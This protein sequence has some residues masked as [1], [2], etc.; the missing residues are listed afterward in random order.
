MAM[1]TPSTLVIKV[2]YGD[3]QRRFIAGILGE[4]LYYSMDGLKKKI[5]FLFDISPNVELIL[6]YTDRDGDVMHLV[7][8]DDICDVMKQGLNPLRLTL[9]LGSRIASSVPSCLPLQ[10][11]FEILKCMPGPLRR[12]LTNNVASDVSSNALP[13]DVSENSLSVSSKTL[14]SDVS[15]DVS[16]NSSSVSS[17]T[18]PSDVS[19]NSLSN[20]S[21]DHNDGNL[22]NDNV[23][24]VSIKNW[25]WDKCR[26]PRSV[27][28]L[29]VSPV[30][31]RKTIRACCLANE[32]SRVERETSSFC[33]NNGFASQVKSNDH[34]LDSFIVDSNANIVDITV[35]PP[36]TMFAKKWRLRNNGTVEWPQGTYLCC[37]SGEQLRRNPCLELEIPISGV[38]VGDDLEI[39]VDFV[40]P[41][42]PGKYISIW[43]MTSPDRQYFGQALWVILQVD[44]VATTLNYEEDDSCDLSLKLSLG[45][46]SSCINSKP[47][48]VEDIKPQTAEID[49]NPEPIVEPQI[50]DEESTPVEHSSPAPIVDD[51]QPEIEDEEKIPIINFNAVPIVEDT[52]PQT[53]SEYYESEEES[54]EEDESEEESYEETE[55]EEESYEE[56]ESEEEEEESAE[57]TDTMNVD[58][59]TNS[60][61]WRPTIYENYTSSILLGNGANDLW[62]SDLCGLS[63]PDSAMPMHVSKSS[64]RSLRSLL[65]GPPESETEVSVNKEDP[66]EEEKIGIVK[67]FHD[68]Y[69]NEKKSEC[70]LDET[71]DDDFSDSD[72]WDPM[73][74]ELLEMGFKDS[75]TNKKLLEKNNGSIMKVVL[76]LIAEEN[77]GF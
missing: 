65:Y 7:D 69:V 33:D 2:K 67:K 1:A 45:S 29:M 12:S 49:S 61:A 20:T 34:R 38:P 37:T 52:E 57:D 14:P 71:R 54:Y 26:K 58:G 27:R 15:E 70:E 41:E 36:L 73:L 64:K 76:D 39:F 66:A 77:I 44:H 17:K 10:G 9:L 74:E 25:D 24:N 68:M 42:M 72:D 6:R 5:R 13:S 75:E 63:V 21:K 55:S 59:W 43:T 62:I 22:Q 23:G 50:E 60:T 51:T 35:T 28:P 47:A 18:L 53:E 31:S 19:E 8:D 48:F 40:A 4:K 30:L 32:I 11:I 56:T 3:V 46:S 16:E